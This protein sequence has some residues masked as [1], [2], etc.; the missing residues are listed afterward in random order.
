MGATI[1]LRSFS[2][3]KREKLRP[4]SQLSSNHSGRPIVPHRVVLFAQRIWRKIHAMA[5]MPTYRIDPVA[6]GEP[7]KTYTD[8]C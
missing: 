2:V 1:S 8:E 7:Y 6:T 3:G 4:P 5:L